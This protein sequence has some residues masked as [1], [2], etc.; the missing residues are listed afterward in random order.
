MM[1][2]IDIPPRDGANDVEVDVVMYDPN[3][4]PVVNELIAD[5]LRSGW[6][7]EFCQLHNETVDADVIALVYFVVWVRGDGAD[8]A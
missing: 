4:L 7:I 6:R 2:K 3:D 1:S 5:K 8:G